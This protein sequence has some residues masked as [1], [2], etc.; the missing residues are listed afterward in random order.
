MTK[1]FRLLEI[2]NPRCTLDQLFQIS[3]STLPPTKPEPRLKYFPPQNSFLLPFK[4]LLS[5]PVPSR[6]SNPNKTRHWHISERGTL[7]MKALRLPEARSPP[8][9]ILNYPY[10][11]PCRVISLSPGGRGRRAPNCSFFNKAMIARRTKSLLRQPGEGMGWKIYSRGTDRVPAGLLETL[12]RGHG[13]REREMERHRIWIFQRGRATFA[14]E[15]AHGTGLNNFI[16]AVNTPKIKDRKRHFPAKVICS[17]SWQRR[18]EKSGWVTR[19]MGG[20]HA[21]VSRRRARFM[22]NRTPVTRKFQSKLG[23]FIRDQG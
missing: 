11:N 5:R 22:W 20:R 1:Q 10:P 23:K 15:G 4:P 7:K 13:Q 18:R 19:E 6:Q 3:I 12:N 2:F 16:R 14:R 17:V 9:E 21:I 8:G